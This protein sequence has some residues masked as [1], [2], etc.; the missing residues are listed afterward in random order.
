MRERAVH[1][2]EVKKSYVK[3]ASLKKKGGRGGMKT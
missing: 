2:V 1:T 3:E